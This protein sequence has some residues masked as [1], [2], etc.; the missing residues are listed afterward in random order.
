M[1][2]FIVKLSDQIALW[3]IWQAKRIASGSGALELWEKELNQW[4]KREPL[5]P[6]LWFRLR[7]WAKQNGHI[8]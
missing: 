1:P 2:D 6:G 4:N 8:S 3:E 7:E 5:D